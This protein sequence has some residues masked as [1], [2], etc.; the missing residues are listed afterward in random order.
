MF[1]TALEHKIGDLVDCVFRRY[2]T[3]CGRKWPVL[4]LP[5]R[6]YIRMRLSAF[7]QQR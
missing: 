4:F 3:S 7:K 6:C 2:G 5:A 1:S